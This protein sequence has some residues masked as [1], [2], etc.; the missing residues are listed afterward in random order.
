[1]PLDKARQLQLDMARY[2]KGEEPEQIVLTRAP[3]LDMWEVCVTREPNGERC[4]VL[5]GEVRGHA[6]LPDGSRV[7][8]SPVQWLDRRHGWVRTRS[9][10][11][12]LLD[13]AIPIDGIVI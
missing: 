9:R 4:I 7:E 2:M 12:V 6:T 13:A 8:T 11:Y 1:M 5:A 3:V 10:V